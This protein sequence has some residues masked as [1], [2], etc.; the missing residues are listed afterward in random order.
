VIVAIFAYVAQLQFMCPLITIAWRQRNGIKIV[1]SALLLVSQAEIPIL[2]QWLIQKWRFIWSLEY[3]CISWLWLSFIVRNIKI[4]IS[5]WSDQECIMC[6][7]D[8]YK[9]RMEYFN[10]ER[11]SIRVWMLSE[12]LK[13]DWQLI[14]RK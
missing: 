2:C 9:I 10:V 8:I 7:K 12:N 6:R 4:L 11:L 3:K 1:A 14:G 13:W 5:M